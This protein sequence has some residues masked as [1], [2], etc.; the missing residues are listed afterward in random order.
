MSAVKRSISPLDVPTIAFQ[1]FVTHDGWAIASHIA[2]SA[3][4]SMFPFLILLTALAPLFG[5]ANLADEAANVI[6][7]AWPKEVGGPIAAEVHRVLSTT[8]PSILTYG[9]ILALYFSSSGVESL[10]VGLNRAYDKPELRPWWLTRLESI[11]YVIFGA[12]AMLAFGFLVV[13]GPLLWRGAVSFVPQL[14]PF[15]LTVTIIRLMLATA[16][17]IGALTI[18]HK[19]IAAGR[20]RFIDIVPG[21]STTLVLWLIGGALFGWYLDGFAG[22]YVSTYGG[23]ATAMVALVF[24]YWLAAMFIFGGEVNGVLIAARR[25][26]KRSPKRAAEEINPAP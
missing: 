5:P 6:L 1:R 8:R 17:I 18:A 9:A 22:A 23:L 13:L 11:A 7:E 10:R 3:L 19:F 16:A 4:T 15:N 25:R 20:R 21:I 26:Q 14:A 2:L 24:L 12:F